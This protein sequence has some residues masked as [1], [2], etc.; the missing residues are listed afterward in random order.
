VS[1][2]EERQAKILDIGFLESAIQQASLL[3]RAKGGAFYLCERDE[4]HFRLA[5]AHH[6][7]QMPD[8]ESLLLRVCQTQEVATETLPG[9]GALLAVPVRW[10][11]R[12]RGVFVVAASEPGRAF[13][14]QDVALLQPMADLTGAA[15]R[16]AERLTR[17]TAQFRAL[18]IID[19]A[20]TSSLQLDRVLNLILEKAVLLV[21]AEHGSLRLLNPETG[22]LLLKAHLGEGWTPEVQARPFQIGQG[23]TGWVAKHR[24]PYLCPDAHHDRRNVVLFDGM[25]SGVAVPLLTRDASTMDGQAHEPEEEAEKLLGVLLLESAR[26][27]AF[28][29]QDVELLEAMAQEAVIAIQNATQHQK[30]QFMH[31]VL[32]GEQEQR[33][34]AEKW[35]VM[36]QAATALAHRINNLVGIVP[37]SAGEIRRTLSK[38]PLPPDEARWIE[39]NLDRIDRNARFVLRLANALFRPFQEPE[40]PVQL[41]VNRLLNEAL[42]AASLPPD[43]QVELDFEQ[44]LPPVQSNSLLVDIFLELIT[45]ARKA[46]DGQSEQRLRVRT[47][48]EMDQ[49]EPWVSIEIGDSGVGI[50]PEQMAHLWTMFQPTANW[51]AEASSGFGLWWVRTF[52]ERHGGTI[53]CESQPGAGATFTIRLPVHSEMEDWQLRTPRAGQRGRGCEARY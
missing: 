17:M 19:V 43:V 36:G 11:E 48:L 12:V 3:L 18:H 6:L 4:P 38:L 42:Q 24:R 5:A 21:G 33:V 13:N 22:D 14:G 27:A 23:L 47:R 40:Q 53:T 7:E 8:H 52:I 32:Q 25:R 34:A 46:M 20:L 41:D 39:A 29:Q 31:Q 49:A 50:T 16:Q 28:D 37:A 44:E 9:Q 10:E 35:T 1:R 2:H 51:G 15:L 26:L 45:N 30:L